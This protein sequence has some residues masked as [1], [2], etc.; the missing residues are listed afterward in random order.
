MK[1]VELA[2]RLGLRPDTVYRIEKQRQAARLPVVAAIAHELGVAPERLT[3]VDLAPRAPDAQRT[4][5]QL[6]QRRCS[7]CGRVTPISAYVPDQEQQD[8][9][10]GRCRVCRARRARERYATDPAEREVQKARVRRN[11]LKRQAAKAQVGVVDP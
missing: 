3:G 10:Y 9:R 2:R 5:R 8:G 1:Q 6:G 4:L 7:H 11:R